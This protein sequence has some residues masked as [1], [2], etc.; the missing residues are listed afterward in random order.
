MPIPPL[1]E[2]LTYLTADLPGIGGSLKDRPEDFLVEERPLYEPAGTGDH[3]YL[4]LEKRQQT[5]TDVVRRLAKL[6]SVQRRDIGYAGLKDKHAI[7]RQHFSVHL[8][9]PSND[10]KCLSRF[11][12]LPYTLLWARRHENKLRRGHLAGN[13]FEIR[14]RHVDPAAVIVAHRTLERLGV[15]GVPNYVGH[16]RFGYRQ[17]NHL[18]GRALI[19]R[20]WKT[21]L[22]LMLGG[23]QEDPGSATAQGRSRYEAGDHLGALANWPRYL[24]HDRQALDAL[25]QGRS[26]EQAV[27]VIESQQLEFLISAFQSAIFNRVLDRRVRDNALPFDRLVVGDLAWK[28]DNRSVFAVDDAV[29]EHEN[30]PQGRVATM[31][32]SPSG[33]MWGPNMTRAGGEPAR[34]ELEHLTELG[35]SEFELAAADHVPVY[36]TR[37]PLRVQL[38]DPDVSGGSDEH[39]PFIR[40]AFELPRGSFA[41]VVLREVMK[42]DVP[43]MVRRTIRSPQDDAP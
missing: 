12:F 31:D 42:M 22:D 39:G 11:E 43:R 10:E 33:P 4:F 32:V 38:R 15:T 34:C 3:L 17:C 28:H 40:M 5:T 20:E 27:M 30:G 9:D 41:T 29:A 21:L 37:R 2:N 7:T 1:T 8:P 23:S 35:L 6:F 19:R 18:L 25:R 36:G 24:R 26:H 16:Q 13:R 14:L